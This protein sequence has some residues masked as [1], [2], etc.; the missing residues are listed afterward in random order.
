MRVG[1]AAMAASTVAAC[2]ERLARPYPMRVQIVRLITAQM[3]A[4]SESESDTSTVPA[5]GT[6]QT[7]LRREPRRDAEATAR[8]R[9]AQAAL[10]GA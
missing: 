2:V 7:S 4:A 8:F 6:R 9:A 3:T 5:A 10:R 1:P